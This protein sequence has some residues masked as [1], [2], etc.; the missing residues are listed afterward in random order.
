MISGLTFR[1]SEYKDFCSK[2]K[3]KQKQKSDF[4]QVSNFV[5]YA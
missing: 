2:T 4:Q 1:K 5:F 3:Q